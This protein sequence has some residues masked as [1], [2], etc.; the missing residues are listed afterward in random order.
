MNFLGGEVSPNIYKRLDM[1]GNGKWFETAKNIYFGTTGDFHNRRGFE[2]IAK[3]ASGS[4]GEKIKLIPFIFN[5]N[6]TYCLEFNSFTFR[7]LKNGKLLKDDQDNI[8]EVT[9]NGVSVDNIDDISYSQVGDILYICTGGSN[10]IHTITRYSE[11]DWRWDLFE[12]SIPPMRDTNEDDRKTLMFEQNPSYLDPGYFS[13]PFSVVTGQFV[14][15]AV[16]IQLSNVWQTIYTA[17]VSFDNLSTFVTDFNTNQTGSN[18]IDHATMSGNNVVFYSTTLGTSVDAVRVK[19]GQ[20]S[21]FERIYDYGSNEKTGTKT[22]TLG[23]EQ[24]KIKEITIYYSTKHLE[25]QGTQFVE[26]WDKQWSVYNKHYGPDTTSIVYVSPD[27][28]V[29]DFLNQTELPSEYISYSNGTFTTV[30]EIGKGLFANGQK[31]GCYI[32]KLNTMAPL[33][34]DMYFESRERISGGNAGDFYNV[35][36]NFDFFANKEVGDIFAVDSIY[37]PSRDGKPGENKTY[38]ANNIAA[39]TF[40]TDPFWSNG[41]WRFVTSGLF[42]GTIELQYSYD[43]INW[44]S[45]RNFSSSIRVES[46]ISYSTN[47][48]EYGTL[49]V[50]DNVLLRLSFKVTSAT[51]LSVVLDTESYKNRAYYKIFEKDSLL[52]NT[53]AIVH[54]EKYSVGTPGIT[55]YNSVSQDYDVNPMYEWSESAWSTSYGHPKLC[56]LYQNRLGLA[57]TMKDPSTIWFSKTN[58]YKDFSTKL[59]YKDDDPITISV[60]K[61]TGISE[62]T[63]VNAA[64]K[65][66]FFTYD[67]EQGIRDE[68]AITQSNKEVIN[69]TAYGSEPI[70]TRVIHNR[71]VFVERGGVAARALIYD[72]SQENFEAA[73]LT[74]PY[75]HLLTN[76]RIV[77]SEYI[78]GDYKC[79]LMLT[80]AGRILAFKYVPDQKIEACSWFAHPIGKITNMCVVN[81]GT[82]FDLYIALD[83]DNYKCLEYM[84]IEPYQDGT[85]LDSYQTFVFDEPTDTVQSDSIIP[86]QEYI[87][88][89]DNEIFKITADN[90]RSITLPEEAV[91]IT[92]GLQYVSEA[93]LIEPNL[94]FQNGTTNYNRKNMFKAHFE[95][96]NSVGFK[97]GIKNRSRS[98]KV[99]YY[100]EPE[101][102]ED[103][104]LLHSVSRNFIM[105]SSYLEPNML[106]F[107][108]EQPFPMHIVN[109]E[110]E[111]DYGG[112]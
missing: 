4:Y 38:Y 18:Y 68:G 14:G 89:A 3:T 11:T 97:V 71:I 112:K 58:N 29:T 2:Y 57:N 49:D 9:H 23:S 61:P 73:D 86:N 25:R 91:S 53:K 75:K 5:K 96:Q 107:V 30:S 10:P 26:V 84:H 33:A 69:F 111:V 64:R 50:D 90:N 24:E 99:E 103:P 106:S 80:S 95:C 70:E 37:S 82:Y 45:H 36:A 7:V 101:T 98:F 16:E 87:V 27:T 109:A 66:F 8:I 46:D 39:G 108:Q 15:I 102:G 79:Y 56:F 44:N 31:I 104:L 93:T 48:N 65:L 13:I 52:P 94:M 28:A 77:S 40:T 81:N 32:S 43:G 78:G 47:Y 100:A 19:L 88:F 63:G 34:N 17:S 41:T 54:C 85:Y 1:A 62:I 59:E 76:E 110:V 60:L 72:Y 42:E 6:Q 105:Q 83:V 67:G 20:G 55:R 21:S 35:L 92:I 51:R 12:Y 22:Y 74:I